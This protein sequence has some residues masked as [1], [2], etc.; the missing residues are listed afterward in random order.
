M[1]HRAGRVRNLL[2]AG[3]SY[4]RA[5]CVRN[6]LRRRHWNLTADSIRHLLVTDFR[7]HACACD[8]LFNHL[9]AP[10]AAANRATR[11][12]DAN[13]LCATWIAWVNNAFLN[14]WTRNVFGLSDPFAAAFLN[15]FALRDRLA[16][17][18]AHVLVAS[19]GFCVICC[20]ANVFVA[21]VVHRL[22]DIVANSPVT[23]LIDWFAD[24]VA[25]LTI[26][27]LV[28]RLANSAGHVTIACLVNGL[29]DVACDGLVAGLIDRLAN[30]I[31]FITVA[32]FINVLCARYRHRFCALVIDRLHARILLCFPHNFLH[33][34]TLWTA[35]TTSCDEITTR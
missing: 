2:C 20:A 18:V 15:R 31:T 26:A 11:T 23:S 16:N 33:S 1:C 9:W 34:L 27:C 8:R 7:N 25:L 22:A 17:R 35:S 32:C 13:S 5:C 29:A 12:L 3:F 21:C 6:L 28:N 19:L 30:R 10:F 4:E 24:R 14:H